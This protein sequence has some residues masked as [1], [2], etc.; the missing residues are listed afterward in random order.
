M[1]RTFESHSTEHGFR[2]HWVAMNAKGPTPARRLP[3]T[4]AAR[5]ARSRGIFSRLTSLWRGHWI[6]NAV[7]VALATLAIAA[8]AHFAQ[9]AFDAALRSGNAGPELLAS[10]MRAP[11][12]LIKPAID[13]SKRS[14]GH[15]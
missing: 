5:S 7:C 1:Q 15:C 13:C 3:P 10:A 2:T 8:S 12:F 11:A 4:R 6:G 9:P 14:G